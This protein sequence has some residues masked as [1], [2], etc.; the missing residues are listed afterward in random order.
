[1][2]DHQ[3]VSVLIVEDFAPI[4]RRLRSLLSESAGIEV[5]GE[6][7]TIAEARRHFTASQPAAVILDIQ[8]PDGSG[9]DLIRTFKEAS[10][11]CTVIVLTSHGAKEYREACMRLGADHFL[12]KAFEFERVVTTLESLRPA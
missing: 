10:P 3:T 1:M 6:A 2:P 8:M 7:G 12:N 5:V 9:I 4:R 11:T